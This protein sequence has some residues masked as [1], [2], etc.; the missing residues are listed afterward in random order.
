MKP[1]IFHAPRVVALMFAYLTIVSSA[2]TSSTSLAW[3]EVESVDDTVIGLDFVPEEM[4]YQEELSESMTDEMTTTSTRWENG[5]PA[6]E[7]GLPNLPTV[8]VAT[9]YVTT[10]SPPQETN[11][12]VE[13]VCARTFSD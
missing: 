12:V 2:G 10:T 8:V 9:T 7:R 3:T 4:K 1:M 6:T 5:V 13:A 11:L